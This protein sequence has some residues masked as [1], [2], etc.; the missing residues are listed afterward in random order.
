MR[1]ELVTLDGDGTLW[2]FET[3]M[4]LGL[5]QAAMTMA[6]WSYTIAGHLPTI[7]D[8]LADREYVAK[9]F[10]AEKLPMERLRWLAL[11]RSLRRAKVYRRRDL[12]D[13]L[14]EQFMET[15]NASV[16]VFDDTL[17]TLKTLATDRKLALI[18]NGNTHPDRI[19]LA[20]IFD[21]V[22]TAQEHGIW[23]PD[24][25]IY[26]LVAVE[27][28]IEAARTL[29]VGDDMRDDIQAA[30]KAGFMAVWMNRNGEMKEPWCR[31]D[32]EVNSLIELP[33]VLRCLE[34]RREEDGS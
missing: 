3:G 2:D 11:E 16:R 10:E 23:K 20:G 5:Q 1:I 26:C 22:I 27:L 18:T 31:P 14:Y 12:V 7:E 21:L 24:P 4:L 6:S 28:G 19:G 13:M 8:L 15:R 9:Q 30:Q 29:H 17:T 25:R 32:A 34:A 33:V